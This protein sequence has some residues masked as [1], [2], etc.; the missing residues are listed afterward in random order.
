MAGHSCAGLGLC[1]THLPLGRPRRSGGG[2]RSSDPTG[3]RRPVIEAYRLHSSR[4]PANDG[5]GAAL[6]GGRCNPTGTEAIYTAASRPLAVLEIVVHCWV[7]PKDFVPTRVVIPD[8]V[9]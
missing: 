6:W 3:A 1:H 5:K 2:L 9:S 7:L 4:Y 8:G